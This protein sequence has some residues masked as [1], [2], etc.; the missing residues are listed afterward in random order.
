[1]HRRLTLR[2]DNDAVAGL[3]CKRL[4]LLDV[5]YNMIGD[6]AA[7]VLLN[8]YPVKSTMGGG[9]NGCDIKL[10]FRGNGLAHKIN[11]PFVIR[12]C[13]ASLEGKVIRGT[14]LSEFTVQYIEMY[15][16][17]D[18]RRVLELRDLPAI[19]PGVGNV[20]RQ[21]SDNGHLRDTTRYYLINMGIDDHSIK[22]TIDAI[23]G[24]DSKTKK[25]NAPYASVINLRHN[26]IGDVGAKYIAAVLEHH[27]TIVLDTL[28]LEENE[29]TDK[30]KAI[31]RRIWRSKQLPP[32]DVVS[33]K[34]LYLDE[35]P[36]GERPSFS[37][38]KSVGSACGG[39]W[40]KDIV[41]TSSSPALDLGRRMT[42]APGHFFEN[43]LPRKKTFSNT[44]S[45]SDV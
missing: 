8:A 12:L 39:S 43:A 21:L 31:L 1:M 26:K 37:R 11:R 34:G 36:P 22:G 3:Y 17:M 44:S 20:M 33:G 2:D 30:G 28:L 42:I 23:L 38:R 6:A 16:K 41:G 32:T 13:R 24:V 10:G 4:K 14:D 7:N 35:I 5:R 25:A 27:D 29:I 19:G 40:G 9:N 18:T 45:K 15:E